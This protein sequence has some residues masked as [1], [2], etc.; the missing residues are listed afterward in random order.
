MVFNKSPKG[1]LLRN[2][3]APLGKWRG[4]DCQN[5]E[6]KQGFWGY[7]VSMGFPGSNFQFHFCEHKSGRKWT[8]FG[9]PE[10]PSGPDF[11]NLRHFGGPF[12]NPE[13]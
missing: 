7:V 2:G 4:L 6:L 9:A 11:G 5:P 12:E 13:I 8:P 3:G 10:T 1:V